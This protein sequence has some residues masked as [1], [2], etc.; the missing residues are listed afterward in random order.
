MRLRKTSFASSVR[1]HAARPASVRH[2]A[3][4]IVCWLLRRDSPK[5]SRTSRRVQITSHRPCR[6][7]LTLCPPS[8]GS[9]SSCRL[10]LFQDRQHRATNLLRIATRR[11]HIRSREGTPLD[12]PATI[13]K[14]QV[15]GFRNVAQHLETFVSRLAFV[16]RLDSL[17][18]DFCWR[19][20]ADT[21]SVIGPIIRQR[22]RISRYR[23]GNVLLVDLLDGG[24][25][26]SATPVASSRRGL[27]LK[28][29]PCQRNQRADNNSN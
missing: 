15:L 11:V 22:N 2:N 19:A 17:L 4:S 28:R 3:A 5:R 6:W 12:C 18:A 10:E 8:R 26:R 25:V 23:G 29:L 21:N 1:K 13:Q 24:Q 9:I 7:D 20:Y 16:A 27:S 14:R